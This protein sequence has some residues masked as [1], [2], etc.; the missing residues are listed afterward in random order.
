M[1]EPVER[2]LL[3]FSEL[4]TNGLRHAQPPIDVTVTRAVDGW[5]VVVSDGSAEAVPELHAPDPRRPGQHGLV[6]VAAVSGASGWFSEDG[7]KHVWATVPDVPPAALL[8]R[9]ASS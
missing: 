9:L 3:V 6:V 2:L 1:A 7:S 5:L 4:A 8:Q